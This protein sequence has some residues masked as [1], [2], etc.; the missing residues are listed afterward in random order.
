MRRI[1][2]PMQI[3][4]ARMLSEQPPFGNFALLSDTDSMYHRIGRVGTPR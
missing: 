2:K 3:E 1:A 4:P